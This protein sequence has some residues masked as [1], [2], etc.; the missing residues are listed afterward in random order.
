MFLEE[1]WKESL[2]YPWILGDL[3][4]NILLKMFYCDSRF[5]SQWLFKHNDC[6][7]R[8]DLEE[9]WGVEWLGPSILASKNGSENPYYSVKAHPVFC[10][11]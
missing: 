7:D 11:L 1:N 10:A 3:L 5:D 2:H 6:S 9:M 8:G 4:D